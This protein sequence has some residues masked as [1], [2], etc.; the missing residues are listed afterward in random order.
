M[1]GGHSFCPRRARYRW[2]DEM[3]AA[4]DFPFRDVECGVLN[5]PYCIETELWKT[6]EAFEH[7]APE[8]FAVFT[9]LPA[10]WATARPQINKLHQAI[11]RGAVPG[12]FKSRQGFRYLDPKGRER[13]FKGAEIESAY[14]VE[15]GAK[16]GM[17]H[18]NLFWHGGFIPQ[19]F[20]VAVAVALGWG[21]RVSVTAWSPLTSKA[22][23]YGMKEAL[24]RPASTYGMKE[25]KSKETAL[26]VDTLQP[27]QKAY[28][29]R[30]GGRLLHTSRGF[31]R[32]GK[33]GVALGTRREAFR[34][35]MAARDLAEGRKSWDASAQQW[36]QYG[37]TRDVVTAHSRLCSEI[38]SAVATLRDPIGP[39]ESAS[40]PP[41]LLW[42]EDGQSVPPGQEQAS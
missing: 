28:L 7:A 10:D 20:L 29:D 30:N 12:V 4:G 42:L 35:A 1:R 14:T 6:T 22:S 8:R 25:A 13:F 18:L 21:P 33:G 34:A 23:R 2:V 39:S 19:A 37:P 24:N 15:A 9:Q 32:D 26:K 5:C 40:K 27:E 17:I 16:T 38:P 31:W 11:R 3:A 41:W 36:V